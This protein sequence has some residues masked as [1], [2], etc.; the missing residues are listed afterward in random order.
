MEKEERDCIREIEQLGII[1]KVIGNNGAHVFQF[2]HAVL[3][4][5]FCAVYIFHNGYSIKSNLDYYDEDRVLPLIAGLCGIL[6]KSYCGPN[7]IKK[8][9]NSIKG[10]GVPKPSEVLFEGLDSELF[11]AVF[12]E[13]HSVVSETV[14]KYFFRGNPHM[15]LT[16][17]HTITQ[18]IFFLKSIT[19]CTTNTLFIMFDMRYGKLNNKEISTVLPLLLSPFITTSHLT[20]FRTNLNDNNI[21]VESIAQAAKENTIRLQHLGIHDSDLTDDHVKQLKPCIPHLKSLTFVGNYEITPFCM[22]YI[23]ESITQGVERD[24][25]KL[26]ELILRSCNL[27]DDHIKQLQPCISHLEVLDLSNNDEITSL[28][29]KYISESIKQAVTENT[30][31]LKYLN[32]RSNNEMCDQQM[33]QLQDLLR[34]V[35]WRRPSTHSLASKISLPRTKHQKLQSVEESTNKLTDLKVERFSRERHDNSQQVQKLQ[36]YTLFKMEKTTQSPTCN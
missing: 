7:F 3:Q 9:V 16:Y 5:F 23:S 25:N 30:N 11:L 34:H 31:K 1:E 12:Y 15:Y 26:E 8:I 28:S 20:F 13:Y 36:D 14:E 27:H 22:K 21:I 4:D 2:R 6:E 35:R 33:Q 24:A 29:I 32:L 18:L 10:P 19:E 17:N